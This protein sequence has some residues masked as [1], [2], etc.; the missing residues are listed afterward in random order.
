[1]VERLSVAKACVIAKE[2]T[3]ALVIG[4]DQVAVLDGK[5][6]GKPV[7]HNDA[8]SQLKRASGHTIKLYTGLALVDSDRERIQSC[9]ETYHVEM[10]ELDEATIERYLSTEKPYNCCGSLRAEGLGIVLLKKL[11]G[12][13]P[14]T[15]IGLPL[16]ALVDMLQKE[17][18]YLPA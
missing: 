1:M 11:S 5:I 17:G 8:V 3:N 10:R 15:L 18:I 9:V 12:D 2:V 14:N 6:V 16:I 4:S 7:D 13:D